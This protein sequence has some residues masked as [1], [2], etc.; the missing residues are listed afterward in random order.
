[1]FTATKK[2]LNDNIERLS[3][4]AYDTEAFLYYQNNIIAQMMIYRNFTDIGENMNWNRDSSYNK[5]N[6]HW[7]DYIVE[8][9]KKK[10]RDELIEEFF[11]SNGY[12]ECCMTEHEYHRFL[13]YLLNTIFRADKSIR[14][15]IG[16]AIGE[17]LNELIF[18]QNLELLENKVLLNNLYK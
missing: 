2:E 1:M 9:L 11:V 12:S 17:K 8:H 10:K 6:Q 7:F 13:L 15:T 18:R 4:S 3:E 16:A 14:I 5:N